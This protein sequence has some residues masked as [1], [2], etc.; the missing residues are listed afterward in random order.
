MDERTELTAREI[1]WLK[2]WTATIRRR[3]V[4]P[5]GATLAANVCLKD[6][7]KEFSNSKGA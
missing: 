5:D 1:V 7:D 2:A 6:F 4:S 3:Q